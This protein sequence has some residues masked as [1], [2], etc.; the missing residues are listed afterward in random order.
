M[1]EKISSKNSTRHLKGGA[2]IY[3]L[4]VRLP[5]VQRRLG[6]GEI[7]RFRIQLEKG[8]DTLSLNFW[9]D[10]WQ[11]LIPNV[12]NVLTTKVFAKLS[13][14][15]QFHHNK[16]TNRPKTMSSSSHLQ[17]PKDYLHR[18][19]QKVG[20]N[21]ITITTKAEV[22]R[23]GDKQRSRRSKISQR[24]KHTVFPQEK[25]TRPKYIQAYEVK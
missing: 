15:F 24:R 18:R 17:L 23:E 2:S 13:L 14:S 21:S 20:N 6:L 1:P 10:F 9:Q 8:F 25:R 19:Q 7:E 5:F 12:K 4:W 11:A 22:K 16:K 3:W